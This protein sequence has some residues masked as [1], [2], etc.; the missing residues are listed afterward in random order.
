LA[1]TPSL[2]R[3]NCHITKDGQWAFPDVDAI[4]EAAEEDAVP[5]YPLEWCKLN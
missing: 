2:S 4:Y 3:I 1:A 5:A